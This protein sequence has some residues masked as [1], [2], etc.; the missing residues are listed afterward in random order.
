M[1]GATSTADTSSYAYTLSV[2]KLKICLHGCKSTKPHRLCLP[3]TAKISQP[4]LWGVTVDWGRSE[5]KA[6]QSR[7]TLR[8]PVDYTVRGI[9]QIRILEW[10]AFPFSRESSQPREQT[11]VSHIAGGFFTSWATGEA[12]GTKALTNIISEAKQKQKCF[13]IVLMISR[14]KDTLA[15]VW[16]VWMELT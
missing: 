11:Q 16:L 1:S 10:A 2:Y 9:L 5:V 12:L 14:K 4:L 7:P 15:H 13:F 3:P 6:A 8:N